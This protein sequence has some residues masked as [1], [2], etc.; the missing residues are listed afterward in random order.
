MNRGYLSTCFC[1]LQ[2]LLSVLKFSVYSPLSLNTGATRPYRICRSSKCCSPILAAAHAAYREEKGELPLMPRTQMGLVWTTHP[3]ELQSLFSPTPKSSGWKQRQ[4]VAASRLNSEVWLVISHEPW[5]L[6]LC[7][8]GWAV[9]QGLT[10]WLGRWEAERWMIT[11]KPWWG[12]DCGKT[13]E[14]ASSLR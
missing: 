1:F 11:N 5:P 9:L 8:D 4:T 3:Q 12:Q 10:L 7:T 13:F 6:T 2:F 14:F